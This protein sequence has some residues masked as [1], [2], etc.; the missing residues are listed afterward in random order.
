MSETLISVYYNGLLVKP[1]N[2]ISYTTNNDYKNDLIS[3]YSYTVTLKGYCI[4]STSDTTSSSMALMNNINIIKGI[5]SSNGG[6]LRIVSYDGNDA[7]LIFY[8]VDSKIKN[9]QFEESPNNWAKYVPFTVDI[10]F[11]H[12]H[13][14]SDL[15][16]SLDSNALLGGDDLDL[17]DN[18]QS[19]NILNL[20][21]H[22]IKEFTENFSLDI[23]ESDIF[24]QVNLINAL[25]VTSSKITNN[26]F[27]VNY[28]LSAT[29]KHDVY[30]NT[31]LEE[32]VTLPAWEHAK[33]YV[34]RRLINQINSMFGSF[35]STGLSGP[36]SQIHAYGNNSS[37]DLID[38][39]GGAPAFGIFD[40]TISFDVSESDGS[41]SVQYNAIVKQNCPIFE[42]NIGCLNATIHT[43]EKNISRTFSA[44]EET[45]LENQDIVVTVNGEIKGLL[46]GRGSNSLG[47]LI[48]ANPD[49]PYRGTFLLRQNTFYDKNDYAEQL[50]LR[51]FDPISY[52]LTENFKLA[53][54]ITPDLLAV[55]PYTILKPTK[56][57]LTRNYL[58][59]IINYTAEYNNKYNCST[60]HFDIQLSVEMPV[61]V[62]AEFVI[63]NNNVERQD[64]SV[65]ASGYTVIQKMGTQ[66]SKKVNVEINGNTGFDLGKC[67]LGSNFTFG[68]VCDGES[69][70]LLDLNYFSAQDFVIPSG[71]IIPIIGDNY[72]LISKQKKTSFPKGDFSI[73][74]QYVCADVCEVKYFEKD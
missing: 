50:L 31:G 14:G 24:N 17:A 40:E 48:I 21:N 22:K 25:G 68:G 2:T 26:F 20:E 12:L 64:G 16:N 45:N 11:N 1:I 46:P 58:Q 35:L 32:K 71:V 9:L 41:F 34:H 29:G 56:M 6:T 65:C 62:I 33:R 8:A 30:Y 13:M 47:P 63:P 61:P 66:T 59:G 23:N 18:L 27:T 44:N 72:V 4:P 36:L 73:S 19:A 7:K 51:I 42:N 5:F 10:D 74:L 28:N 3:N 52:D 55:N 37:I 53:L 38:P 60:S 70:D 39:L 54:G 57:N 15:E 69:L 67:C 49:G 43:V